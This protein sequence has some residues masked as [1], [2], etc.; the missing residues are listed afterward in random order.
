[1][2]AD[3]GG[4]GGYGEVVRLLKSPK[5]IPSIKLPRLKGAALIARRE[6]RKKEKG[7]KGQSA[8]CV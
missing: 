3:G 6:E 8:F 7:E 5:L 1:M 4:G 2:V